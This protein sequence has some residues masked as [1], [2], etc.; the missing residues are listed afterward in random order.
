MYIHD[1]L[2]VVIECN[3]KRVSSFFHD[4]VIGGGRVRL[5]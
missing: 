3:I 4:I 1:V 5:G 2:P